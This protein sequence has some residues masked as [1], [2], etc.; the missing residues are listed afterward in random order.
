VGVKSAGQLTV[1]LEAGDWDMPDDLWRS[2]EERTRPTEDYLTWFN[3]SNYER[4]ASATEF[5]EGLREVL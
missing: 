1:N 3:K 5:Q 4:F 2:L